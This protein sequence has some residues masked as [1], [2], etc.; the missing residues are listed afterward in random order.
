VYDVTVIGGGPAGSYTAGRLAGAGHRV[1]VLEKR[2]AVGKTCCAGIVGQECIEAFDIPEDVILRRL[3]S[4]TLYSPSGLPLHIER[5]DPQAA[6]LDRAAF[7]NLLARRAQAAGA[8]Y[9]FESRAVNVSVEKDKTITTVAHQGR[10]EAIASQAVVLAGGFN[11]SLLQRLGLGNYGDFTIGAQAEVSAPELSEAEVWFGAVAP[12]FFAWLAPAAPGR[13]RAG[14]LARQRPGHYLREWLAALASRGKITP[15]DWKI[16]YG[17]IPLRPPARSF[18]ER[19]V[20]VGDAAGQ[21]K[22]TSGGGIYYGRLGA[23]AAAAVLHEALVDGDLSARR[24]ARYQR[25]WRRV[26]GRELRLG[27]WARR[28]YERL[29]DGRVD[30]LFEVVVRRGIDAA[31]LNAPDL[32]FDW[33]SQTILRLLRYQA[34]AAVLNVAKLPFGSGR[35]D[36]PTAKRLE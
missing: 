14:L 21:V 7:D 9:H 6:I 33:H 19:L 5:P 34:V 30:R 4:A 3:N 8:A 15:E 17:G 16:S 36:P 29:G 35:I 26:L 32:S 25:A 28:L 20:V 31:L 11:P 23:A 27:Y 18:G 12:G 2:A 22:P 1:L 10:E 13:A 24:L